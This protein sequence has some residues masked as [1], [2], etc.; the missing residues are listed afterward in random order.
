MAGFFGMFDYNKPGKGVDKDLYESRFKIF[1]DVFFRKFWK[2]IQLNMLYV[3]LCI[4]VFAVMFL[5]APFNEIGTD[6]QMFKMFLFVTCCLIY[7]SVIGFGPLMPGVSYVLRNFSRQQHS[8]IFSDFFEQIKKNFKQSIIVFLIDILFVFI[9]YTNY[10]FYTYLASNNMFMIIAKT[11]VVMVG[12][13][14]FMMHFYIYQI[15]VTFDM[16]LKQIYRNSLM[17][18]LAKLPRNIGVLILILIVTLL[19]FST[20]ISV[21]IVISCLISVVFIAYI[22]NFTSETIIRKYLMPSDDKD[23]SIE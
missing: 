22:V 16:P 21:G 6:I 4:P 3:I 17:L 11:F 1:F 5:V 10:N 20:L 19:T 9:F 7:I 12:M 8:W 13:I 14:Y 18:T 15:M 23:D 2:F